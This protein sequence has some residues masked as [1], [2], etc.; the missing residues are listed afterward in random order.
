MVASSGWF[1]TTTTHH[2]LKDCSSYLPLHY[3]QSL[4]TF[5]LQLFCKINYINNILKVILKLKINTDENKRKYDN[6][7]FFIWIKLYN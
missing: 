3:Y 1:N 5:L 7:V 4:S 2:D 6:I